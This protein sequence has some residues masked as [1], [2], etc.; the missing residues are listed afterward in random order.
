MWAA[1]ARGLIRA[2]APE[3]SW[4]G[5]DLTSAAF[6]AAG[7]MVADVARSSEY[8]WQGPPLSESGRLRSRLDV[9]EEHRRK[10]GTSPCAVIASVAIQ[11][12]SGDAPPSMADVIQQMIEKA[13]RA[14]SAE[15]AS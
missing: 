10:H 1:A 5:A 8:G 14:T 6:R 7:E 15:V 3:G 4:M 12:D 13:I 11:V 9:L 2:L